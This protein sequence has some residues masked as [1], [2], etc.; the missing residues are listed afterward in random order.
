MNG[1]SGPERLYVGSYNGYVY[2]L[3]SKTMD[4]AARLIW[5]YNTG[6]GRI[7]GSPAIANGLVYVGS[8]TLSRSISNK[9]VLYCLPMNMTESSALGLPAYPLWA[10]GFGGIGGI[11]ATAILLR[12][13][14]LFVIEA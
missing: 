8:D 10:I 1:E 9:G 11:I 6:I 2:C 7:V 3:D 14:N 4:S 12:K 13:R 5:K